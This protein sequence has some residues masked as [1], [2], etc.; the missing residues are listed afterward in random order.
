T[1][2][3]ADSELLPADV[4]LGK[5]LFYFAGDAP[6]GQNEM[7][8]EG[9]ISCASC[10]ID[11]RHDG[12]DWDFTQRGEGL[13]NTTDLRGRSGM[14]HGN[15][16]WTANFDEIEDFVLDIVNEFGG[17]GFLAPGETPHPSLGAPNHGRS[18]ELDALADYVT[19]L[20]R[21]SLPKSP[22]RQADGALS[23]QATAGAA[24]FSSL[25]CAGCHRPGHD[26]TDRTL[27]PATLHDVGPLRDSS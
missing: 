3:T 10:H 22:Y 15:V 13:R 21:D 7:S 25:G 27:G 8:F 5:R 4:L 24:V 18:A 2:S 14:L 20:G 26:L 17:R 11:G 23:A 19:S 12:R 1:I 6:D 16:H 9:Y